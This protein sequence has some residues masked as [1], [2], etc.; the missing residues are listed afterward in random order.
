MNKFDYIRQYISDF[1]I[2]KYDCQNRWYF[3]QIE[4]KFITRLFNKKI[5]E[6]NHGTKSFQARNHIMFCSKNYIK[7]GCKMFCFAS[8][9]LNVQ[10]FNAPRSSRDGLIGGY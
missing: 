3:I 5:H 6:I 9:K 8:A 1:N 7:N 10:F 2:N 4:I